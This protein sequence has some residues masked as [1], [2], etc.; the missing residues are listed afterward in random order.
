MKLRKMAVFTGIFAIAA[1]SC[2]GLSACGDDAPERQATHEAK[3]AKS[4]PH[5]S[6][7]LDHKANIT[8]AQWLASRDED[9][10]LPE[11]DPRVQRIAR[12]L[13]RA[14]AIFRESSRMIANRAVQLESMLRDLGSTETAAGILAD[15]M[16]IPGE[17]G[18]PKASEP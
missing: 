9:T 14:H 12:D 16:S 5:R 3:P 11:T 18:R 10:L 13:D 4:Q 8:P 15:I 2:L 1:L 7:W 17:V 6:A